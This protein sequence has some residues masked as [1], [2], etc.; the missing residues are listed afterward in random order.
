M[1]RCDARLKIAV[2][3]VFSAAIVFVQ[4]WP[5]LLGFVGAAI[6]AII[7]ARIPAG[8]LNRMLIP[9]YVMAGFSLLFNV[10]ASP[11][12][13]GLIA[14]SLFAVRMVTLVAASIVVCLTTSSSELLEAFSWIISP[15]RRLGAP[16][17]DISTTLALSIRFIPV[18]EREFGCIRAAQASRG[19]E[20]TGS[21][22]RDARI[23]GSAVSALFVGLFRHADALATAMDAR[24]YGA[25]A[26]RTCLKK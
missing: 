16:V 12:A 21:F 2:L 1:H 7:A 20:S 11:D 23:W 8:Q 18:V 10:I 3:F 22:V 6:A 15:L 17:D 9:V 19:G 13:S 14:G 26:R 4:T 5:V 25:V 24:C